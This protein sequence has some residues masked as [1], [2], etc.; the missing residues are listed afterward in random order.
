MGMKLTNCKETA[1]RSFIN[2]WAKDTTLYCSTCGSIYTK[3]P[4]GIPDEPCC[5][6]PQL[7]TNLQ[8]LYWVIKENQ[9]IRKTRL[10]QY[11]SN[12]DKTIRWALA[13]PPRLLHDLE[14][15]S[16]NTLKEPF[17]RDNG[18]MN[19]FARSFPQFRTCEVI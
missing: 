10:N 14:Q 16:L 12:K 6:K 7:G 18:E 2:L 15:Y 11:A 8:H 17:L 19:D 4:E 13:M 9:M 1:I 5:E 3:P